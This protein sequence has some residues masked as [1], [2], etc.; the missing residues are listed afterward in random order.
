MVMGKHFRLCALYQIKAATMES[1]NQEPS[2]SHLETKKCRLNHWCIMLH[3]EVFWDT[4]AA[5]CCYYVMTRSS[6]CR[7]NFAQN[8]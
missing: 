5:P 7:N 6:C 2:R 3:L 8:M 1:N 4:V